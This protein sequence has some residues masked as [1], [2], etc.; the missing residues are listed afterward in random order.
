MTRGSR[1]KRPALLIGVAIAGLLATASPAAADIVPFV[2]CV[3]AGPGTVNVYFGYANDGEAASIG[4]G[5]ENQVI[6]GIG[7][8]GQPTIFN[9]GTYQRV[10][11]AVWNQEAFQGISWI[12]NGHVAYATRTG[13]N[14]SPTCIAGATGPASDLTPTTARL[15]AVVGVAGQKTSYRFE[16][17]SGASLD[18]ST[19]VATVESGQ[20]TFVTEQLSGLTP[21]TAY[22][23]RVVATDEDGT[24]QGELGTFTTPVLP[25]PTPEPPTTPAGTGTTTGGPAAAPPAAG[26]AP[27][28][29]PFAISAR[30][31]SPLSI[32]KCKACPQRM[33]A[34]VVITSNR[35]AL[36]SI[37]AKAGTVTVATR[38]VAL[39]AGPNPVTLC[40]NKAG[41]SHLTT[42]GHPGPLRALAAISARAGTETARASLRLSFTRG[43]G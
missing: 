41:R 32:S 37:A 9:R 38:R 13:P 12:L 18:L 30:A 27:A 3:G 17:G 43:N 7:Y 8:Q 14:P 10:F 5:E 4:F 11:R 39:V 25:A 23:Y 19:P 31:A 26:A 22:R 15:S 24:T 42:T 29:E 34:G 36:A 28:A 20:H 6:P 33:A 16:Y 1:W 35:P 2:D 21:G 40:L